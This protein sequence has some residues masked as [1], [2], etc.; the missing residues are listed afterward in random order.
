M[1]TKLFIEYKHVVKIHIGKSQLNEMTEFSGGYGPKFDGNTILVE[2]SKNRYVY[3]SNKIIEF[4]LKDHVIKYYSSV[5]NSDVP[6]PIILGET[7]V[8]FMLDLK[9]VS[10]KYFSDNVT[11]TEW[12]DAYSMY[13]GSGDKHAKN[14]TIVRKII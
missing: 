14:M 11:D 1:Y 5:G 2:I 9:Y 10:R 7:N 3:I 4:P 6:Y 13:Y 12:S 8:Y